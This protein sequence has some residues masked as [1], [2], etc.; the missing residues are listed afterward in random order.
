MDETRRKRLAAIWVAFAA[1]MVLYAVADG[2][3]A[4]LGDLLALA[5]ATL[6]VA[7]AYVY[8]ANPRGMLDFGNGE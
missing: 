8:Y 3:A 5:V 1:V 6:G 7:L 2:F 4:D